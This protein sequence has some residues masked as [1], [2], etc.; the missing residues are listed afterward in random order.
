MTYI[1]ISLIRTLGCAKPRHQVLKRACIPER[2]LQPSCYH[3]LRHSRR[4]KQDDALPSQCRQHRK[5]QLRLFLVYPIA[6]FCEQFLDSFFHHC[7]K[8]QLISENIKCFSSRM[9]HSCNLWYESMSCQRIKI[10]L[11]PTSYH[12]VPDS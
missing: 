1:G 5:C 11:D 9:Y 6:Q 3:R 4:P 10:L 8:V 12:S 7:A 2:T